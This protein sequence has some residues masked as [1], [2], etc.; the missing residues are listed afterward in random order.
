M[1]ELGSSLNH[2]FSPFMV[3]SRS[4]SK[5]MDGDTPTNL[6]WCRS[7]F[8]LSYY[9]VLSEGGKRGI[10][11]SHIILSHRFGIWMDIKR[12]MTKYLSFLST[13]VLT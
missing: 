9:M 10:H 1:F 8:Y 11:P 2:E 3:G 4:Y 5:G 13:V 7:E 12:L 6:W